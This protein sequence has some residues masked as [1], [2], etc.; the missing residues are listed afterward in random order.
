MFSSYINIKQ[1]LDLKLF[2]DTRY[3]FIIDQSKAIHQ[4]VVTLYPY[5]LSKCPD[6]RLRLAWYR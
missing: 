4:T 1:S 5:L 2:W 3:A 6:A